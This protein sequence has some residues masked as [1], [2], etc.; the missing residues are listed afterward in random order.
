MEIFKITDSRDN[1]R[2]GNKQKASKQWIEKNLDNLDLKKLANGETIGKTIR[3][4]RG[5]S[6]ITLIAETFNQ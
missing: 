1:H 3:K 6:H 5:F 4:G 2:L